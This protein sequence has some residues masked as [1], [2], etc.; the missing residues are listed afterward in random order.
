MQLLKKIATEL[1][2]R[3]SVQVDALFLKLKDVNTRIWKAEDKIRYCESQGLFDEC[4]LETA[5]SIYQ[6][7]DARAAIKRELSV[8]SS[9]SII[10]E[11]SYPGS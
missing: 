6:L 7:N 3:D 10:E 1:N 11:K 9:S 5:R 8:L 2:I 4:F